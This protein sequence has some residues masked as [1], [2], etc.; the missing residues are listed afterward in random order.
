[1]FG[2]GCGGSE[3]GEFAAMF[4]PGCGGNEIGLA[5]AET[6]NPDKATQRIALLKLDGRKVMV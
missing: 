4:G 3:I 6:V 2:P 5:K 1:M